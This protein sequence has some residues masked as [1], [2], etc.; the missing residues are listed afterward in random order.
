MR[1]KNVLGLNFIGFKI[2]EQQ[3]WK[4]SDVI[5]TY[6]FIF[7]LSLVI[8][9]VLMYASIDSNMGL[10]TALVQ[11]G[12]SL[13]TF[14]IVY[15]IVTR[16]YNVSFNEAF[17]IDFDKT[18]FFLKNGLLAAVII[19]ITTSFINLMFSGYY[20]S[21]SEESPYDFMSA[22]KI[23]AIVFLAIFIAPVIEEIFF[24]GFMQP[25][26]VKSMGAFP[27]IFM[28]AVIFGISHTQYINY[29]IALISV[30]CIGLILGVTK[31]YTNSILPGI[32][33]HLLNNLLAVMSLLAS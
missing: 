8:V 23:R 10:Y 16:K 6:V 4:I 24:R 27:G 32:F 25:A 28:T 13:V 17:G 33:A 11:L 21:S 1:G 3:P 18:Y 20:G 12:L 26:L 5:F 31:Y 19:I 22:D 30:T 14:L 29:D 9:G 7:V 2:D 15:S